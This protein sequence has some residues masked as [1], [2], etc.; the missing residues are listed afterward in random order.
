VL[1]FEVGEEV[2]L[3]TPGLDGKWEDP[4]LIDQVLTPVTYLIDLG[5]RKN[6]SPM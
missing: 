1:K 4:Y 2:M 6:R 5:R 3:R